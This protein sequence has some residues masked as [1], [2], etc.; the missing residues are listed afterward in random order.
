M[1]TQDERLMPLVKAIEEATGYRPS[2]PTAL[3]WATEGRAG[4]LMRSSFLGGRRLTCV[5]WVREFEAATTAARTPRATLAAKASP[6][7]MAKAKADLEQML[8]PKN[9]RRKGSA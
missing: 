2:L 1:V 5:K 8:A 3:R 4:Y 7:A 9:R 6:K